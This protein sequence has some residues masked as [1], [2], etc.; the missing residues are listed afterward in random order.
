M[1]HDFYYLVLTPLLTG[2]EMPV[3]LSSLLAIIYW[4]LLAT[5][6]WVSSWNKLEPFS[7][8]ST[9]D[10]LSGS[11]LWF[12]VSWHSTLPA[13]LA[14]VLNQEFPA[15][16]GTHGPN[17][18]LWLRTSPEIICSD[19]GVGFWGE[20]YQLNFIANIQFHVGISYIK[21]SHTCE[22]TH[23]FLLCVIWQ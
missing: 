10:K 15:W 3:L 22:R 21:G 13:L 8:V 7:R 23:N 2:L 4:L 17:S 16:E 14:L 19:R 6:F 9:L 11:Q 18:S 12:P 5:R 20:Y 1:L